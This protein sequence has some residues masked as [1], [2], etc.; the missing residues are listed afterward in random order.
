MSDDVNQ[1]NPQEVKKSRKSSGISKMSAADVRKFLENITDDAIRSSSKPKKGVYTGIVDNSEKS[2]TVKMLEDHKDTIG[3]AGA[4]TYQSAEKLIKSIELYK[5][6]TVEHIVKEIK[7]LPLT[8]N[9]QNGAAIVPYA[10]DFFNIDGK[11]QKIVAVY[12]SN[13]TITIKAVKDI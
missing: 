4:L 9:G 8:I 3:D 5:K 13:D 7:Q 11:V 12:N 1:Q 2:F 6:P 10:E